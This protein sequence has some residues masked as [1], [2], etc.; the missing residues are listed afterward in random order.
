MLDAE[1]GAARAQEIAPRFDH[2][3][4]VR[5]ASAWASARWDLVAAYH[6]G[7]A[8]PRSTATALRRIAAP[9]GADPLL[10]A[11]ARYLAGAAAEHGDAELAAALERRRRRPRRAPRRPTACGPAVRSRPTA[12]LTAT[13]ARAAPE[14]PLDLV[15]APSLARPVAAADSRARA[16]RSPPDLRGEVALVT[17]ASPGS[18]AAE[19][20][21]WLLRG[22]ATVVVATSTDTPARRRWYRELYRTSRRARRRAARAAGEPRVVRRRRRAR[23]LARRPETGAR[24][25]PDLRLDP[26]RPTI[27]APFAALPTAGELGDAGAGSE[28]ALRL[29][30]LGVERLVAAIAAARAGRARRRRRVLLPLSPN[31]GGFGG[32]GA[33]GET[34][35]ALE[36]LL[37]RWRS[38]QREWGVARARSSRRASAGCAA[39]G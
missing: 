31:H 17:G 27:V 26:L 2:R 25:R 1:L 10:A 28:L 21:R 8:R 37:A 5:F 13:R 30:L 23:G 32:D 29:Q 22:G 39:P 24:G 18:I 20:V 15:D 11:T 36:V 34:K 3:R 6:D 16:R 4:H 12:A 33:Y 7:A 38:E 14:R 35:A 9:H 19:L